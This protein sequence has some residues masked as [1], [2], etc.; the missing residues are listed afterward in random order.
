MVNTYTPKL[1]LAKPA[2]GDVNW[3]IPVNGNWDKLDTKVDSAAKTALVS[4]ITVDADKNWNGKNITNLGKISPKTWLILTGADPLLISKTHNSSTTVTFGQVESGHGNVKVIVKGAH[5]DAFGTRTF[6]IL[7][8]GIEI[9]SGS[10]SSSWSGEVY[11][12]GAYTATPFEDLAVESGDV[13][14]V[15]RTGGAGAVT[16]EIY[17]TPLV[18]PYGIVS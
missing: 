17:A 4:K 7:K 10:Q 6:K 14:T 15:S 9:W 18:A 13:L 5:V 8:N 1:N 11:F 16:V 2:H 12:F 3:H